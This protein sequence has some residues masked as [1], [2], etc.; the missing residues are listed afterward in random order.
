MSAPNPQY[1]I[2]NVNIRNNDDASVS[3][4]ARF[5]DGRGRDNGRILLA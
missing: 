5:V 2:T 1:G 4:D 3:D